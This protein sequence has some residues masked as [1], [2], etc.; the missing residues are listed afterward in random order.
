MVRGEEGIFLRPDG[1]SV[2]FRAF[3]TPLHDNDGRAVGAVNMILDLSDRRRAEAAQK[4]LLDELNHRVKN[5]LATVQSLATQSFKDAPPDMR[6]AFEGR[7]FALSRTHNQLTRSNWSAADLDTL[8]Q[9]ILEPFAEAGSGRV[10][11]AGPAVTLLPRS[12][13]I[14]SMMLH[15]LA[16]NA[17]KYGAL[18]ASAGRLDI[19]WTIGGEEMERRLRLT[20]Q[21]SG[22]PAVQ[23]PTHKGFGSRLIEHGTRGDLRGTATIDYNPSGVRCVF[24]IAAPALT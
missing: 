6:K 5:T 22:G 10:T 23:K 17:A 8:L 16:T 14:L 19:G 21:E 2:P 3:P 24:D 7:L 9:E 12:A 1:T 15:E 18:S 11:I 13:L 20:W 4:A